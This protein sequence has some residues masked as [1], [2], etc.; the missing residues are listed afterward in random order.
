MR[1]NPNPVT[2]FLEDDTGEAFDNL[3]GPSDR[4]RT[5]GLMVPKR[6][7]EAFFASIG[8]LSLFCSGNNALWRS[9]LHTLQV[10]SKR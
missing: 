4:D 3:F 1:E 5:Y 10:L 2:S 8:F 9:Y 7:R 6:Y